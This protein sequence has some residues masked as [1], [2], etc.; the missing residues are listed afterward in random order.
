MTGTH[1]T[2]ALAVEEYQRVAAAN[3]NRLVATATVAREL[4]H[5]DSDRL[6]SALAGQY[7]RP[8]HLNVVVD[9][10]I[11]GGV[12]VEIGDDVIDGT[13]ASRL[14]DARRWSPAD[15][16]HRSPHAL[17]A[18]QLHST[19]ST[20]NTGPTSGTEPPNLTTE[21]RDE[22][23]E[24]SIRPEEIRDALRTL[25]VGLQARDGQPRGGR[26]GRRGR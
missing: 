6:A 22:M 8:V 23:T 26:H 19:S 20:E 13:V 14:D 21:S 15:P 3:R 16:H 18:P 7:G 12:K 10:T 1:R 11:I 17:T 4:D 2:V 25:R 24:L 5:E 9:P